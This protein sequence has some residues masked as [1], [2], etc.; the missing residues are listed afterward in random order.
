[1]SICKLM[2]NLVALASV[3]AS[4][5]AFGHTCG[6]K[7][8]KDA[9]IVLDVGHT[10]KHPGA[11]SARGI[12]EYDFNLKLAIRIREELLRAGFGSTYV[13][14]TEL[15]GYA[16]LAE[17]ADRANKMGADI[18]ISIH[19]D[20]VKDSFLKPW[21]YEGKE[22]F[23]F[24]EA[25]GFSLHVSTRDQ[26]G[27]RFAQL[28]ADELIARGLDFN[29]VHD[30]SNPA[31]AQVPFLDATRGIYQRD[32]LVVLNETSMP[33]VLLEAGVIVNRD[34]ELAVST[35]AYQSTIAKAVA[36][37][38]R[39]FCNPRGPATSGSSRGPNELPNIYSR[40]RSQPSARIAHC[41][42]GPY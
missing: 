35:P 17:R 34:E 33:A 31:G 20:G 8:S 26:E 15:D 3:F 38:V 16:G 14:V 5:F 21:F 13:R 42:P 19:H 28:L 23:Y 25:K 22:H 18:F 39:Q 40:D 36:E 11:I 4:Q 9:I 30:P 27:L 12:P 32:K 6:F 29:T 41:R 7:A 37:A 2:A 1:V 24:D 10:A